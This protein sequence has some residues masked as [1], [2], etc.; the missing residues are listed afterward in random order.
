MPG[1]TAQRSSVHESGST[2]GYLAELGVDGVLLTPVHTRT[3]PPPICAKPSLRTRSL[4]DVEDGLAAEAACGQR[5]DGVGD[6]VPGAAPADRYGE[7][8]ACEEVEQGGELAAPVGQTGAVVDGDDRLGCRAAQAGAG[9]EG[10]WLS[11]CPADALQRAAGREQAVRARH[12]RSADLVDDDVQR[13]A[14][15]VEADDD[16]GGA[17]FGEPFAALGGADGGDDMCAADRGKLDGE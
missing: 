4:G 16:F 1:Q 7:P 12:L 17:E 14:D 10:G 2:P 15:A 11:G 3:T 8:A 9:R 5:L 6:A 13:V